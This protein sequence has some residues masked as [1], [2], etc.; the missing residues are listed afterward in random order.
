VSRTLND[1][2]EDDD[3][4]GG[5]LD[6]EKGSGQMGSGMSSSYDSS[7]RGSIDFDDELFGHDSAGAALEL[8]LPGGGRAGP[9]PQA[10]QAP[11]Q[12]PPAPP[13]PGAP[14]AT[15]AGAG[16]G[17]VVPDLAFEPAPPPAP[18]PA[19]PSLA[20]RTSASGANHRVAAAAA[21][22]PAGPPSSSGQAIVPPAPPSE[23]DPHLPGP[24]SGAAPYDAARDAAQPLP[25]RPSAA[26]I[27]AKYPEPPASLHGAA[28]YAVRVFLRQLEL[29][30]DL[31]SLRRRRSPDVPL[32]EAA[33]K[34]YEPKTFRR[35]LAITCA[36]LA[37]ATVIF[38]LPVILRFTQD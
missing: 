27:I 20:P 1:D 35:G 7:A 26:A 12:R 38:F 22:A 2:F 4:P 37:V 30:T 34:A 13:A 32:Y 3:L 29:R 10:L 9:P 15:G 28:V 25:G 36:L 16:S 8:D 33:L 24:A 23:S 31:E 6:L 19:S 17:P 18:A 21:P 11:Q 14:H 5:S